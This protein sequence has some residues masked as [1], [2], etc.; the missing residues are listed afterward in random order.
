MFSYWWAVFVAGFWDS[1]Q[2]IGQSWQ[3]LIYAALI[4]GFTAWLTDYPDEGWQGWK[5]LME[6][7]KKRLIE[8]ILIPVLAWVPFFVLYSAHDSYTKWRNESNASAAYR[9]QRDDLK[10]QLDAERDRNSP[11]F[12]LSW[13]TP[14]VG[15]GT[16]TSRRGVRSSFSDFYIQIAVLNHGAPSVIKDCQGFAR[17]SDGTV[18]QGELLI[19]N[20]K[21]IHVSV[22]SQELPVAPE[23]M[24][25]W[26][27]TPIPRGGRGVG[28]VIFKLP[29]G[30]RK[31]L[32]GPGAAIKVELWDIAGKEYD[33][34]VPWQK[35][36]GPGLPEGVTSSL[37]GM[38]N[39]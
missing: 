11:K 32:E 39:R 12:E 24:P 13:A 7:L 6:K 23:L 19:G 35:V 16:V 36:T 37:P 33:V 31:K 1:I 17:L 28:S 38:G 22:G 5:I 26:S 4:V 2:A 25:V 27:I 10:N 14:V 21:N 29:A 3:G 30:L 15:T 20:E 18:V 34:T 8:V 9:R